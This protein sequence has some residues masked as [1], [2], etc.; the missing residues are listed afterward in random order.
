VISIPDG[1]KGFSQGGYGY[2]VGVCM[3]GCVGD[4]RR[5]IYC[6]FVL[7][8]CEKVMCTVVSVMVCYWL[9]ETV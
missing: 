7:F 8:R 4:M 9:G 2:I 1:V 5:S 3:C 6:A